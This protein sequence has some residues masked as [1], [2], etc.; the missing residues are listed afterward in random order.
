MLVKISL[1]AS[2]FVALV[3]SASKLSVKVPSAVVALVLSVF[4][5]VAFADSAPN[6]LASSAVI[7]AVFNPSAANALSLSVTTLAAIVVSAFPRAVTSLA[8]PVLKTN[9]AAVA[10]FVSVVIA[11]F[12]VAA[13][14]ST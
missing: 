3:T 1:V 12:I 6:A 10:L 7:A 4:I 13:L 2:A 5:A 9:S 8:K 14:V 11:P